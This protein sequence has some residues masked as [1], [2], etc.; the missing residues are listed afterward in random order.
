MMTFGF[1]RFAL[2]MC[3]ASVLVA[4]CGGSQ[5]VGPSGTMPRSAIAQAPQGKSWM[6]P[7]AKSE[8]LIYAVWWL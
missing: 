2:A 8:V 1:S 3:A 5:A 4:G 6:L 7:E